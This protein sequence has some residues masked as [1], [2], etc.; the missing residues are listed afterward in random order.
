MQEVGLLSLREVSSVKEQ[1][2][3]SLR[4]IFSQT[5]MS[6]HVTC[7]WDLFNDQ[8]VAGSLVFCATSAGSIA[9][10]GC[11]KPLSILFCLEMHQQ[12]VLS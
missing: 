5:Q 4:D 2:L 10:T 6:V 12:Q 8:F 7:V 11:I 3:F 1:L 9:I